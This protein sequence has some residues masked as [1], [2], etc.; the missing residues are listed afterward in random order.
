ML[1]QMYKP[2]FLS[3]SLAV[4]I[5]CGPA[6]SDQGP[7]KSLVDMPII[8]IDIQGHRGARGLMPENSIPGFKKALDI[9]ITTLE[10]D[11]V[12]SKDSMVVLS[13]EPILSPEICLDPLGKEIAEG[14][15]WN[16]FQMT[17]EEIKAFDCGTKPHSR[18]PIQEKMS[19]YKPLLS[20]MID[21]V[22]AY[23]QSNNIP[24][25]YYNIETKSQPAGDNIYHPEPSTFVDLLVEVIREKGI[26][27]RVV[28]QS[29]DPRT[30]QAAH[31]SHKDIRLVLLVENEDGPEAN[32]E[33]LGFTPDI[34]SPYFHFVN[35]ELISLG[36]E[37]GMYIIP[38]TVNRQVDILDMIRL[39]V[40]GIISDYPDSVH[41]A[42]ADSLG[43]LQHR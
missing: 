22:E 12:I 43:R 11:V 38:W 35:E 27:D 33:R 13:H 30:L 17:Y 31:T 42:I 29:F 3:I 10:L 39:G 41:I 25:P 2:L 24:L 5:G 34:Y 7:E 18:F 15:E 8:D 32:L 6:P 20:E 40:D 16:M 26:T 23:A 28:I 14:D 4:F 1:K 21:S 19:V 9:G 37:K 36:Q